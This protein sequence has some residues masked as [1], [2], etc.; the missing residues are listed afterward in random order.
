MENP[1]DAE[2]YGY[3]GEMTPL[4]CDE[5]KIYVAPTPDGTG[6]ADYCLKSDVDAAIAELKANINNVLI[7]NRELCQALQAMYSAEEYTNLQD[8]N[9]QLKQKLEDVQASAYAESVDANMEN[10][11]L[12]RALWLARAERAKTEHLSKIMYST[13]YRDFIAKWV[14]VERKCLKKAEEYK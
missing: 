1:N 8:E 5:L 14:N 3:E 11:R 6:L 13:L 12:K 2:R 4:K 7:Q 9:T 10:R